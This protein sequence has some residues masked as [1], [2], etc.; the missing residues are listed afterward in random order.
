VTNQA[1]NTSLGAQI[2][3]SEK[4]TIE[5]AATGNLKPGSTSTFSVTR[6]GRMSK[7]KDHNQPSVYNITVNTGQKE[8]QDKLNHAILR[9]V[10]MAS[11]LLTI[12]DYSEW[13]EII[14]IMNPSLHSVCST[15]LSGAQIPLK[16]S[17][18]LKCSYEKLRSSTNLTISY[19]GGTTQSLESI[20]SIHVVIPGS[21][22]EAHLV[23][24]NEASGVSHTG[25]HIKTVLLKVRA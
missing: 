4:A 21:P 1:S 19:D 23:K 16:A 3:N 17:F 9:L 24:G 5:S 6:N 7:T 20:Y 2:A 13:T 10:C 22:C 14:S 15:T 11:L 12:L 18:I 25:E 8:K